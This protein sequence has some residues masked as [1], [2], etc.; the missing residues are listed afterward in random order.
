MSQPW[1]HFTSPA[2]GS[3]ESTIV[4][5]KVVFPWPLSPTIAAREPWTISTSI[6]EATVRSA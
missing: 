5:R 3:S 2:L 4:R 1:P 6:P